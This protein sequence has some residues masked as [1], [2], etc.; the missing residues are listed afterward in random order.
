MPMEM[1]K[2][3]RLMPWVIL[4]TGSTSPAKVMVAEPHTE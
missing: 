1:V 4:S 3:K 2:A